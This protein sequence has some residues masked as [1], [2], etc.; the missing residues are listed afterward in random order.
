MNGAFKERQLVAMKAR[1]QVMSPR[2]KVTHRPG[3][4]DPEWVEFSYAWTGILLH[5]SPS[6]WV[7]DL[8]ARTGTFDRRDHQL[9]ILLL[10]SYMSK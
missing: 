8:A 1:Y 10:L 6:L 5:P 9:F 7:T 4:H 3:S 2:G